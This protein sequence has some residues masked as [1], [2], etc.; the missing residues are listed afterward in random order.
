MQDLQRL[1]DRAANEL[2]DK[3]LRVMGVEGKNFIAKNFQDQG[4]TDTTTNKWKARKTTDANGKDITK[5]RSN[6]R[7]RTGSLNQY[8]SRNAGRAILVG[9]NTGGDKLKNS[10]KYTVDNGK[11]RVVFRSY[12]PY[13][14]VHNEGSAIMPKR[15][16]IGKSAHLDGKIGDKIKTELDKLLIQ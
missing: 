5:Y 6:R 8:G 13:A 4:F 2:P 12:K 9:F 11:K 7:G 10:F 3:G 16:F 1:L 14:Q 15:Q